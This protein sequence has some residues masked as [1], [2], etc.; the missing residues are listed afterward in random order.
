MKRNTLALMGMAALLLLSSCATKQR[1]VNDLRA[2]QQDIET[3]G[4]F[5]SIKEW[6]KAAQD[7]AKINKKIYK[8]YSDYTAEELSEIGKLNGQC[9]ASFAKGTAQ[10]L[11]SKAQGVANLIKGIIDGVGE[12]VKESI[13]T[14]IGT[15]KQ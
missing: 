12:S 7:Y 6:T 5:Y 8:H 15:K 4:A 9:A 1:A 2:L 3:S 10:N 14:A 13:G 11:G